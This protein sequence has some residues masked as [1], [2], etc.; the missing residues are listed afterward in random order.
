M[1]RIFWSEKWFKTLEKKNSDR[2]MKL[3]KKNMKNKQKKEKKNIWQFI[4][5]FKFIK[6]KKIK[7]IKTHD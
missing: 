7:F 5:K 4:V 2:K 1:K 6:N 3:R